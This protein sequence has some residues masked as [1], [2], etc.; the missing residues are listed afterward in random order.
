MNRMDRRP[1]WAGLTALALLF[2]LGTAA[3]G[4]RKKQPDSLYDLTVNSLEGEPV[5]LAQYRGQV[6]LVVNVASHCGFTSQYAGLEQLHQRYRQRGFSVLAF[7]CN[8]FG[9]QEPGSAAEIRDFCESRFQ[10][11]FP[12]FAKVSITSPPR[13]EV[14]RYLTARHEAP[15]W[16]FCKYLVDRGG[17][18]VQVFSSPVGPG[19]PKL[20]AAIEAA[21]AKE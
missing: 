20:A 8:D 19:S 21:L 3:G 18:V 9:G 2:C 5:R 1:L 10:V 7:P 14:Y 4:N 13:S 11:T 12:L 6:T 15:S 17:Q 16:N